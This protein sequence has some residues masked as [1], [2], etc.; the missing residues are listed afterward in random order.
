DLDGVLKRARLPIDISSSDALGRISR[1]GN[2][3]GSLHGEVV[4]F[5]GALQ[6][7]RREAADLAASA[8]CE[9]APG[10][11]KKTTILVVGD[12]DVTRLAGHEKSTKHRKAEQLVTQG[13]PIR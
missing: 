2:P 6:I 3:E 4:A 13:A 5:T 1:E 12:V 11:T 7:P 10:V 8:G 9:V